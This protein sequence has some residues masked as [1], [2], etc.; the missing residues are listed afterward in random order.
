MQDIASLTLIGFLAQL[1]GGSLGMAYG[2]TTTAF[3][4]SAG[5]SPSGASASVHVAEIFAAAA[6]GFFHRRHKNIDRNMVAKLALGGVF[7]SALGALLLTSISGS[8]L[9]PYIAVY[10]LL[11]GGFI[12]YRSFWRASPS[13]SQP[14]NVRLSPLGLAASFCDAI[15]GGGWGVICTSTL[16]ASGTD[17]RLVIGSVSTA[18]AFVAL[19]AS[20][21]FLVRLRFEFWRV[22]AGLVLGGVLAAP[23]AP[24]LTRT[25]PQKLRTGAVGALV[26]YL[27]LRT[28]LNY[29]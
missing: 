7:G 9:K 13:R 8:A 3:L 28:L 11:M 21:V 16:V 6:V 15:G 25:L 14:I 27:S 2:V 5:L 17:A 18:R 29:L 4:L 19:S 10:L 26:C 20:I 22:V 1:I 12:L 23:I 24:F